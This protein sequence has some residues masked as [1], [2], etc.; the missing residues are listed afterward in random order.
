VR[1][2]DEF[3][4]KLVQAAKARGA[5]GID[6]AQAKQTALSLIDAPDQVR[7]LWVDDKPSN[8]LFETAA[9]AKLQ[10]EVVSVTDT[11][12]ALE[13]IAK[14]PETF[15]L[16]LS[17]WQRPEPT[18]GAPSAGVH[19]LRVLRGRHL[20]IPVVFYHGSFNERERRARHERALAEGAYGE[21]V[22][23]GELFALVVSALGKH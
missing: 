22:M 19:L 2:I 23:P 1:V 6:K 7:V 3:S 17:D 4:A 11:E 21:A 20:T 12:A 18:E 10:I 16:V 9:L 13:R 8:N 14:D 15:D 5:A